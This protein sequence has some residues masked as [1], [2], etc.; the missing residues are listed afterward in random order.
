MI[1]DTTDHH[2]S[3][4]N[5]N[6]LI[7]VYEIFEDGEFTGIEEILNYLNINKFLRALRP[8]GALACDWVAAYAIK[9]PKLP[10]CL[11]KGEVIKWIS[12]NL[13]TA[14]STNLTVSVCRTADSRKQ[15]KSISGI[16]LQ[17][18]LRNK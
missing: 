4:H 13:E 3:H 11:L 16:N 17:Q 9:C 5:Q 18:N 1:K 14:T 6:N 12:A 2:C 15:L 7:S 8:G 10:S